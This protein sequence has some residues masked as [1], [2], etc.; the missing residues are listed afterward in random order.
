MVFEGYQPGYGFFNAFGALSRPLLQ[1]GST[2]PAV[3]EAQQ[4]LMEILQR[5][6]Q[7]GADGKFG[8]DTYKAVMEV[9]ARFGLKVDGVI[10]NDT[11]TLLL[12]EPVSITGAAGVNANIPGVRDPNTGATP[13]VPTKRPLIQFPERMDVSL[14]G[15]PGAKPE[16]MSMTTKVV[17]GVAAVAALAMIFKKKS[18]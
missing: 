8:D 17:I 15:T 14:P 9:Q 11:W 2:G 1:R 10:G 16:G 4:K 5:S 12:G 6:L 7:G 3:V 13:L 18:A